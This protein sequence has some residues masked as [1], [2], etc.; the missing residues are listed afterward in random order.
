MLNVDLHCHSN[1]SDGVLTPAAVAASARKAGVDVWALT[2]HDEVA[3]VGAARVAAEEEGMRF[4]SGVEISITWGGE[5]V[6]IVGLQIDENDPVLVKGLEDTRSGRDNR[7]RH[8]QGAQQHDKLPCVRELPPGA[9]Q[10][11]RE[12]TA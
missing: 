4:V 2:D 6:H 12:P 7:G 10:P 8:D 5:T 1:V 11:P 9:H 3:G